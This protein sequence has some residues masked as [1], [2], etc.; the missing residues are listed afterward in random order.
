[1]G[2]RGTPIQLDHLSRYL[3]RSSNWRELQPRRA[4]RA[5]PR[6]TG[7]PLVCAGERTPRTSYP[8]LDA[9]L[10]NSEWV[11]KIAAFGVLVF[12]A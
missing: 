9:V 2:S 8:I 4:H 12:A 10:R 7:T 1:M 3:R 6:R 11:L 5:C